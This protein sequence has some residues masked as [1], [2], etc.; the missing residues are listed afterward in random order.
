MGQSCCF[1]HYNMKLVVVSLAVV[2]LACAVCVSAQGGAPEVRRISILDL[3]NE[4]PELKETLAAGIEEDSRKSKSAPASAPPSQATAPKPKRPSLL[5]PVATTTSSPVPQADTPAAPPAPT[6]PQTNAPGRRRRPTTSEHR[7]AGGL[8]PSGGLRPRRPTTP[9]P[10]T[11]EPQQQNG[12]QRP[13]VRGQARQTE[14]IQPST[15]APEAAAVQETQEQGQ[16]QENAR[17]RRPGAARRRRPRTTTEIPEPAPAPVED[18]PTE[19]P[20]RRRSNGRT[21]PGRSRA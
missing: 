3:L 17:R 19:R 18:I 15:A 6:T 14:R 11:E 4:H 5:R 21:F 16:G 10:R 2:L 7:F 8:R 9:A 13:G 20:T 12:R 1:L